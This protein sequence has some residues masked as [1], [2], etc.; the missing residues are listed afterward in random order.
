M[1]REDIVG[2]WELVS[3]EARSKNARSFLPYGERPIGKLIYTADGHMAVTLMAANRGVFSSPDISL[4]SD[5]EIKKAFE[6]FDAY[7]GK[8]VLNEETGRIDHYIE[9]GRIPNW[10]N[11]SHGR[12][13]VLNNGLTLVTDEFEMTGERWQVFVEWKRLAT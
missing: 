12:T 2:V 9:A 6:T 5:E 8:W 13:C 1:K 4:A 11:Q 10:I 7:S 3:V